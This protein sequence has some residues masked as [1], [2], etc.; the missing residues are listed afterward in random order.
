ML[1]LLR[2]LLA[3]LLLPTIA[4]AAPALTAADLRPSQSLDGAW[5][6]SVDPYRDGVAGFHGGAVGASSNRWADVVQADA[7][8]DNPGALFEFDM[9]RSPVTYLPGAWIGHAAEMRY[10]NGL[11]WYQRTFDAPAL[12]PGKRAFLRFGAVDYAA[13]VYVNGKLAGKHVGGFTPFENVFVAG[14]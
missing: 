13:S 3:A 14:S 6:W 10:Y 4:Q 9:Q 8:R 12:A 7:A 11:V 5:H 1:K 2:I